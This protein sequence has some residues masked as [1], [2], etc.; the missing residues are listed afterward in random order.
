VQG[1][2]RMNIISVKWTQAHLDDLDNQFPEMV[3]DDSP[4]TL[5]VNSGKRCVVQY[6]KL[7]IKMQEKR[8]I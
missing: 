3:G 8:L 1:A 6:V 2:N 7:K 5:L 4:N